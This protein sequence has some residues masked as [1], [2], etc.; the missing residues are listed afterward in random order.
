MPYES[1]PD[2]AELIRE[3]DH[4][5][6][7]TAL[8]TFSASWPKLPETVPAR[9]KRSAHFMLALCELTGENDPETAFRDALREMQHAAV[10]FGVN[11]TQEERY[12]WRDVQDERARLQMPGNV[13]KGA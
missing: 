7:S 5:D 9:V 11:W 12:G 13:E 6:P 4:L 10:E 1:M 2:V 3:A 8:L